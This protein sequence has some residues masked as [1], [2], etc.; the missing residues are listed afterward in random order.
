[1]GW[2]FAET[3][4]ISHHCLSKFEPIS[5]RVKLI[6]LYSHVFRKNLGKIVVLLITARLLD[7]HPDRRS[8]QGNARIKSLIINRINYDREVELAFSAF[9]SI[10]TVSIFCNSMP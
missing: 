1:M 4:T 3:R 8:G 6:L 2:R 5:S 9:S 10:S 7:I